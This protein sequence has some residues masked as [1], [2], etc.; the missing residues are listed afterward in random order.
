MSKAA[1]SNL[2]NGGIIVVTLAVVLLISAKG[3]DIG[4]AWTALRGADPLW[5]LAAIGSWCVFMTFEA[6]G[7]HVFFHQQKVKIHFSLS[8]LVETLQFILGSGVS[9]ADD[10]ILNTAGALL[11]FALT[12]FLCRKRR[13]PV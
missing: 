7:L 3:G 9:E 8:L 12:A 13:P 5:I 10:L 11:G 1:R 4:D 2:I 6:M